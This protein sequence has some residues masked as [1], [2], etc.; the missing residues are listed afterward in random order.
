MGIE[1]EEVTDWNC[2]GST[3]AHNLDRELSLALPARILATAEKQGMD[4]DRRSLRRLLS[5]PQPREAGASR[6]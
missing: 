3:A 2:C 1:L 6:G 5:P 4:G